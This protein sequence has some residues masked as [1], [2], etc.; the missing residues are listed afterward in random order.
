MTCIY[1]WTS[2]HS[3]IDHSNGHIFHFVEKGEVIYSEECSIAKDGW[4]EKLLSFLTTYKEL[5]ELKELVNHLFIR[6]GK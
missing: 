6:S 5:H 2:P 3:V 4:Q 1:V